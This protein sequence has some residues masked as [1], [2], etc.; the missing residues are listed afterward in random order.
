LQVTPSLW[1]ETGFGAFE[2]GWR[3]PIEGRNLPDGGA[4]VIGYFTRFGF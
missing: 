2:L 3:V 1:Y 4:L